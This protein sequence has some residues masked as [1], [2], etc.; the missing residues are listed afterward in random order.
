M[1]K[2]NAGAKG[3][4]SLELCT[5][6]ERML[7]ENDMFNYQ[8]AEY[9]GI[10]IDTF[11]RW[12]NDHVEFTEALKRGRAAWRRNHLPVMARNSLALLVTGYET[13]EVRVVERTTGEGTFTET[14]TTTKQV[15]P[16]AVAVMFALTNAAP[17]EFTNSH[18]KVDVS[19]PQ[20]NV[21]VLDKNTADEINRL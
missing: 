13:R 9:A 3:K 5:E 15:A 21:E 4:F 17:D 14:A 20:L 16:N 7:E 2:S 12:Q 6:I 10:C 11:C 1:G 8:I 19:I 18:S